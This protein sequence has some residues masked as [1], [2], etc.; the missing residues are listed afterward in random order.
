MNREKINGIPLPDALLS[1]IEQGRWAAP[2]DHEL[3]ER[4]FS[5]KPDD[6]SF[7]PLDHMRLE[8]RL[9]LEAEARKPTYTGTPDAST[10][11]GDIDL[12][13]AVLIGDLGYDMPFALDYRP[14][15]PRVVYYNFDLRRWTTV[16]PTI[17]DLLTRLGLISEEAGRRP[18]ER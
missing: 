7:Y 17:E 13:K 3:L 12:T 10:P 9:W 15:R 1:V 2:A 16:A 14:E 4:V 6:P 18:T 8:N 5:D 11:P